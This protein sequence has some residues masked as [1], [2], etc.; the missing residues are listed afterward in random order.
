MEEKNAVALEAINYKES[1]KTKLTQ[2]QIGQREKAWR[3]ILGDLVFGGM[4]LPDSWL[5]PLVQ[6]YVNYDESVRVFATGEVARTRQVTSFWGL[7]D[8]HKDVLKQIQETILLQMPVKMQHVRLMDKYLPSESSTYG[9][10]RQSEITTLLDGLDWHA[11]GDIFFLDRTPDWIREVLRVSA[12]CAMRCFYLASMCTDL[13]NLDAPEYRRRLIY[14]KSG[15]MKLLEAQVTYPYIFFVETRLSSLWKHAHDLLVK[16]PKLLYPH[17]LPDCRPDKAYLGPF[18]QACARKANELRESNVVDYRRRHAESLQITWSDRRW[19]KLFA[20]DLD[21]RAEP[22]EFLLRSKRG[23][24]YR[25][26]CPSKP[27]IL[28]GP[29]HLKGEVEKLGENFKRHEFISID[30]ISLLYSSCFRG[31]D[32]LGNLIKSNVFTF[33]PLLQA[34]IFDPDD[35]AL[36]VW[37]RS[38][39]YLFVYVRTEQG[40]RFRKAYFGNPIDAFDFELN[41]KAV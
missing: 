30:A 31:E 34:W 4:Y 40:E 7:A 37:S 10:L 5:D 32:L 9:T 3:K 29:R 14:A 28:D 16:H 35:E 38:L 8:A 13:H 1:L 26:H 36:P 6:L 12:L 27:H 33:D 2:Q 19:V 41:F 25:V 15:G 17:L 39:T 18:I 22:R 23:R 21:D 11:V 20:T 24:E